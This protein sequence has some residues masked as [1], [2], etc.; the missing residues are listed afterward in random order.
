MINH[1]VQQLIYLESPFN[2]YPMQE[3]SIEFNRNEDINKQLVDTFKRRLKV[4]YAGGGEKAAAKQKEKGKM[5]ARERVAYLIDQGTDFMEIGAF[6]ADGMYKEQGG[7]PS[8]GVITGL[9]YVSVRLCVIV[10][11][12]A[13]LKSG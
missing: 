9:G 3:N 5:L 6:V 13:T 11:N 2:K 8:A 10:A 7:C 12:D 4:I 1:N